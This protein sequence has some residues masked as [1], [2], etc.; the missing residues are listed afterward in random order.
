MT[1]D[2]LHMTCDMWHVTH[3]GGVIIISKVQL[4]SYYG[5][6][7]QCPEDSEQKDDQLNEIIRLSVNNK[8][9]WRTA[10]ATPGLLIFSVLIFQLGSKRKTET[11][12]KKFHFFIW[13]QTCLN[14]IVG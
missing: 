6:C 4:L 8:G 11:E 3:G 14:H 9:V 12:E 5:L 10:P 1:P 2:T 13:I 7:R